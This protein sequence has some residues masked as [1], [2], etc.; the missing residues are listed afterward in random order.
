M[1]ETF[2]QV[3]ILVNLAYTPTFGTPEELSL[4][5]WEHAFRINVTSYFLCCKQAGRRMIAQGA[6]A[7]S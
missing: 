3:D 2:G 5:D 1:D 7:A 6:A 4:A